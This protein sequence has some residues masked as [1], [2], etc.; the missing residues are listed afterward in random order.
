MLVLLR[1]FRAFPTLAGD[2]RW[3]SILIN[4]LDADAGDHDITVLMAMWL[5]K[6]RVCGI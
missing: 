3:S 2:E 4:P 5:K 6:F 1:R